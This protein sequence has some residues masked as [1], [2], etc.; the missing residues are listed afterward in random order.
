[1]IDPPPLIGPA[2]PLRRVERTERD[3][4]PG[5]RQGQHD[6]EPRQQDEQ[7]PENEGDGGVHIDVRV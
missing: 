3:R 4:D 5:R 6:A 1:M 2:T 7:E